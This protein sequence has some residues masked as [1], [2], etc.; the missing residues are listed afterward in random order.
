MVQVERTIESFRRAREQLEGTVAF[1][2]TMGALHE[3]HFS[4]MRCA[5]E[6]ADHLVV[7]IFV[8]PTQFGPD[9]D[10]EEYPRELE[11]DREKCEKFG[12]EL[13]FAP[14][15]DLM[16]AED[17]ST[18]VQVDDLTDVMCGPHRPG[19][20][21]GVATVVTKLLNIVQPDVAVFGEKDYQQLAILR[22]MV[23][24]LN[25]PVEI[26]GA[27]TARESDGLAVSSRNRYLDDQERRD[28]R[29]LSEALARAWTAYNEGERDGQ[30]LVDTARE[31]LLEAVEPE[32]IDYVECVHPETL[33]RYT[34]DN[35]QIGDDGAVMAMAVHVGEAGLID[36]LRLDGELPEELAF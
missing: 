18:T 36:N 24:D 5:N 27:P 33:E 19:H 35:R 28:A 22:R 12:G 16:Y 2:P 30:R 26:I 29:S 1:V 23:R 31:R 11:R 9:S 20:F 25:I 10:Y 4:L 13:I 3:G 8:N 14:T 21:E 17:H 7:S 32:A 6:H 15:P 34:G